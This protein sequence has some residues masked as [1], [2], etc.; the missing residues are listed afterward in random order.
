MTIDL[1]TLTPTE[2]D[3]V[4]LSRLWDYH[5]AIWDYQLAGDHLVHHIGTEIVSEPT[6]RKRWGERKVV[7]PKHGFTYQQRLSVAEF[8]GVNRLTPSDAYSLWLENG[9]KDYHGYGAKYEQALVAYEGALHLVNECDDEYE[10]RPW[11][12]Y[13]LV[14][15]SDGH[16]HSS[17]S[18]STCNK[19]KEPT[20]FTLVPY[21]SGTSVSEAVADLGSALC[22]VCF[23]DA[24]VAHREQVKLSAR[25]A[26]ILKEKGS[27]AFKEARAKA[28]ADAEKRTADRCDGSGLQTVPSE[29]SSGWHVCPTCQF[30]SQRQSGKVRAHR[31]PRYYAIKEG[32][33]NTLWW[34]GTDWKPSTKKADLG[35]REEA[36]KVVA[37]HGGTKVRLD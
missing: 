1:T 21:L 16:I 13:Y 31:R 22:S 20:G 28:H 19:G 6:D 18:C 4:Y 2:H 29:R 8:N 10:S 36:E 23:P 15:S 24:P 12:R 14:T 26:L 37:Q 17:T 3:E 30:H 27:E 11:N 9:S 35:S 5:Q 25:L 34:S 33:I 7:H 32:G